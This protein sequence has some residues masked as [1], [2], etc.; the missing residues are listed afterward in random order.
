[1]EIYEDNESTGTKAP[2]YR[3]NIRRNIG[4]VEVAPAHKNSP[5]L[6]A[7]GANLRKLIAASYQYYFL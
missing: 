2:R 4:V 1:M 3:S 6:L 7:E 5:I